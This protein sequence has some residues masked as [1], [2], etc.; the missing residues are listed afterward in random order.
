[1]PR[2]K[3]FTILIVATLFAIGLAGYQYWSHW[4]H[5]KQ[6]RELLVT[7]EV[8]N[9]L[10]S[11]WHKDV[12]V[13]PVARESGAVAELTMIC[14]VAN[15]TEMHEAVIDFQLMQ[16]NQAFDFGFL[17]M[18]NGANPTVVLNPQESIRFFWNTE[19]IDRQRAIIHVMVGYY[20]DE[21][22]VD[23]RSD[24]LKIQLKP[25]AEDDNDAE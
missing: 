23:V 22:L 14:K 3:L 8:K 10:Q 25:P 15:Q 17:P 18:P 20:R 12:L 21:R 11:E 16:S 24:S 5:K 1:M 4:Y 2:Y 19:P 13:F 9:S 7:F 6:I